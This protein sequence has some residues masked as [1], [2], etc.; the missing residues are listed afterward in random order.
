M[1]MSGPKRDEVLGLLEHAVAVERRDLGADGTGLERHDLLED[2]VELAAGLGHQRRVGGDAVTQA[3]GEGLLDLAEVG[4]V[5]EEL[6]LGNL[7]KGWERLGHSAPA[8]APASTR[9]RDIL[10]AAC[11]L[12]AV[13]APSA[14]SKLHAPPGPRGPA[15]RSRARPVHP[16]PARRYPDPARLRPDRPHRRGR[17]HRGRE[18]GRA[19]RPRRRV[20]PGLHRPRGDHRHGEAGLRGAED[21]GHPRLHRHPL[22]LRPPGR[23]GPRRPRPDRPRGRGHRPLQLGRDRGAA[24]APAGA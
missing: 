21:L 4:R 18:A 11:R 14:P 8:R 24:A 17:R 10:R 5:D 16:V 3:E 19:V 1:T 20:D 7:R 15:P 23:G 12:A 22:P 2:V 9:R 13:P 6:H